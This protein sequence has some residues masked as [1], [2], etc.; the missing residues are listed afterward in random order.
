MLF[1][2]FVTIINLLPISVVFS[3]I[4][5]LVGTVKRVKIKL[6][7]KLF[8]LIGKNQQK[9]AENLK[10]FTPVF[11]RGKTGTVIVL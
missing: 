11:D 8:L 2:I 5:N 1:I 7:S 9:T 4:L 6:F 10:H 3:N